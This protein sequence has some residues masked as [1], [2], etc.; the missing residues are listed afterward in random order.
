MIK[1]LTK[2]RA[3]ITLFLSWVLLTLM[4]W[5]L[6]MWAY[7]LILDFL[8]ELRNMH[9]LTSHWHQ[10]PTLTTWMRLFFTHIG[11]N[12]NECT[13]Q[14]RLKWI[15]KSVLFKTAAINIK[16]IK[17][18]NYIKTN[19]KTTQSSLWCGKRRLDTCQGAA[20]H[21]FFSALSWRLTGIFTVCIKT[22]R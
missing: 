6:I 5:C 19:P 7:S 9:S 10:L 13:A 3:F 4:A 20:I 22:V 15:W 14:T 1:Q 18:N 17:K 2:S 12:V 21:L 11:C 16:E 8:V